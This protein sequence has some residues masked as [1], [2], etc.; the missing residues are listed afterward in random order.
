M[1][2]AD[3]KPRLGEIV[4]F[5]DPELTRKVGFG[6]GYGNRGDGPYA[7]IVINDNWPASELDLFV[8]FPANIAGFAHLKVRRK[9]DEPDDVKGGQIVKSYWDYR[10]AAQRA[11][12][13]KQ[14]KA[15]DADTSHES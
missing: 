14:A 15:K 10:D 5:Y 4:H 6:N 12:V 9:P 2:E 8:M 3:P 13:A 7:A 11:R 1:A